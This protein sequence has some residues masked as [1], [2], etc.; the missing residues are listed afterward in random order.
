MNSS[1]MKSGTLISAKDLAQRLATGEVL[2][3]DCRHDLARIALNIAH[4]EIR[5]Q[6]GG[7]GL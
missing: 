4:K 7:G 1:L 6:R 3:V 2:V 5:G